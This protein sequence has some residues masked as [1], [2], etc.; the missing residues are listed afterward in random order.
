MSLT[1]HISEQA[2]V[3]NRNP[4]DGQKQ[5]GNYR[6]GHVKVHGFDISIENPRGSYRSGRNPETGKE[7]RSR[8][9]H[10]YGYFKRTEGSDGD[11]VDVFIGPHPRSSGVYVIDQKDL[12]T[13]DHDEHKVMLGFSSEKQAREAYCKAFSD[14]RGRARISSIEGM[15]VEGLRNWL[16]TKRRAAGGRVE[17]GPPPFDQTSEVPPFEQTEPV[18]NIGKGEAFLRGAAQGATFNMADEIA[19]ARAAAP[20]YVPELIGPIPARTIAGGIRSLVSDEGAKE[21][22]GGRDYFRKR[23]KMAEEQNPAY[24]RTVGEVAGMVPSMAAVPEA[25]AVRALGTGAGKLAKFGAGVLD[26]ATQ[27]GIA[28]GLAGAGEGESLGERAMEGAKGVVS[29]I[30]GGGLARTGTEVASAAYN[31]FARPIVDT[32]R[33]WAN[34][35]GEASR[36]VAG[37]LR[38]DQE[39]IQQGRVSGMT[40]QEWAAA[41]QRGE[42]VTLADLGAGN[43]Q[44]LLRSSANTS[45]EARSLLEG[46]FS[47]PG[48]RFSS[49]SERVGET[50]RNVLPGGRANARKTADQLVADYDVARVPA[51]KKAYA[52][53][54]QPIFT[55]SMEKLLSSP[56]VEAAMKR[57]ISSGRDRD[58]TMGFGGFNPRVSI[59]NDKIV[60]NRGAD[61][62]PIPPNLQYW[63][64]VKRELDDA[65]SKAGRAGAKGEAEVAGNLAKILRNELD[66]V[67]PSYRKARGIAEDY[68][69]E[70]NALEAG[71]ALAGKKPVAEDV[72]AVM[73]KMSPEER[74]LFREGYTS[75]FVEKVIGRMKDTQD[76]TKAMF[77]SPNERQL[78][79]V[80]YGPGGMAMLQSRMALETIMNGA[81]DALGNSTTARQLIEAGLAGG[82][83]S[84]YQSG[85]DPTNMLQGAGAFAAARGAPKYFAPQA[86]ASVKHFVGKVDAKTARRVA[87]LLTSDDPRLL[88]EGY[89][90][91]AKNEAIKNGLMAIANRL[92]MS[93]QGQ[94]REPVSGVMKSLQG[95]SPARAEEEQRP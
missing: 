10:H 65:A 20:R 27:G 34:P 14:G 71:R 33:G 86:V 54:D 56:T 88:Q 38:P 1:S 12:R 82:A 3:V 44:S 36:R 79:R 59:V 31:K 29:G 45:P 60:F 90:M 17:E 53:G 84:G 87:E 51:Y 25:G 19:G 52:D 48:S 76:I 21:Y 41:R 95:P 49:Q 57:A 2:G 24:M 70:K 63:D 81:R 94:A 7:W 18:E 93:G 64:A 62:M 23:D 83:L 69:G 78:A 72:A 15:T 80:I 26:S 85:W 6:K 67:V 92:F 89:R 50:V 28:G 37:A 55:R 40:P 30:I 91:A 42:P 46:T 75:D 9:P 8:L 4:S 77:N 11:A 74:E 16:K 61:G 58:V 73:R 22:E 32:V 13:G 68:F 66:S 39:M 35:T 5:A 43:T 47:G